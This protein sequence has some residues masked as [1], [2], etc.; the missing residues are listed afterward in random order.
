MT[1][2]LWLRRAAG[3]VAQCEIRKA[4][5]RSRRH[6]RPAFPVYQRDSRSLDAER[7]QDSVTKTQISLTIFRHPNET[8]RTAAFSETV[9]E[10]EYP[11]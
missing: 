1:H 6:D 3:W 10:S 8:D 4:P 2:S 11:G 5:V 9:R 7:N